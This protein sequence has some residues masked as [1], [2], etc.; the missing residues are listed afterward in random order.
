MIDGSREGVRFGSLRQSSVGSSGAG[1]YFDPLDV[2]V[3]AELDVEEQEAFIDFIVDNNIKF[4]PDTDGMYTANVQ[5]VQPVGD[6][7]E[8]DEKEG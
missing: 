5:F 1:S 8:D 2:V 3:L 4:F 7:D 6:D